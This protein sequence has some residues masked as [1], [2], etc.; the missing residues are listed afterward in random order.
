MKKIVFLFFLMSLGSFCQLKSE[1]IKGFFYQFYIT[2]G[3]ET[4]EITIG[5]SI[6]CTSIFYEGERVDLKNQFDKKEFVKGNYHYICYSNKKYGIY[7]I[8]KLRKNRDGNYGIYMM[9]NYKM[10]QRHED[11]RMCELSNVMSEIEKDSSNLQVGI[12]FSEKNYKKYSKLKSIREMTDD[13]SVL[14][15]EKYVEDVVKVVNEIQLTTGMDKIDLRDFISKQTVYLFE[16]YVIKNLVA[17]G[18]SPFFKGNESEICFEKA[19]LQR[20]FA[21]EK[22]YNLTK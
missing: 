5:D 13:D 9:S 15:S 14:F 3:G 11:Y 2:T 20:A 17:L 16:S 6:F 4:K 12:L 10:N 21:N 19:L 7:S 22:L 1:Q 8:L 18:Y